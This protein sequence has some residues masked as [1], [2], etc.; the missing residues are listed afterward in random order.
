VLSQVC[1]AFQTLALLVTLA[2]GM[3]DGF[4]IRAWLGWV[5]IGELNGPLGATSL[6]PPPPRPPL[7]ACTK[8]PLPRTRG[9]LRTSFV[10]LLGFRLNVGSQLMCVGIMPPS[11]SH[12]HMLGMAVGMAMQGFIRC[13]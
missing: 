3:L 8:R 11:F 2:A 9:A 10:L 6:P 1:F 12:T 5:L 13:S 7:T 4:R